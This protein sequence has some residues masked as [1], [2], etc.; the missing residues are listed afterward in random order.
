MVGGPGGVGKRGRG[1]VEGFPKS[2][3]ANFTHVVVGNPSPQH[4]HDDA[5]SGYVPLMTHHSYGGP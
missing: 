3:T 5:A 1:H 4:E 2:S